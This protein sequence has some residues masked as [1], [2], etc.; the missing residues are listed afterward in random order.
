MVTTI[1]H[2][3]TPPCIPSK[4][5]FPYYHIKSF[6]TIIHIKMGIK[7]QNMPQISKFP[8]SPKMDI[9]PHN[10]PQTSNLLLSRTKSMVTRD[11]QSSMSPLHPTTPPLC[12]SAPL[13]TSCPLYTPFHVC[14]SPSIASFTDLHDSFCKVIRVEYAYNHI[15][16]RPVY[17]KQR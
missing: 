15:Q 5:Q 12:P 11:K 13:H 8:L 2:L 7:P 3:C 6:E 14:L 9:M 4:L 10:I 1:I 17:N 16:V